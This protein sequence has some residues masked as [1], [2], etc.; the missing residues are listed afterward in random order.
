MSFL[1]GLF[2][3]NA[4]NRDL[5][6]ANASSS[7]ALAQGRQAAL[8]ALNAGKAP[9]Q[10]YINTGYDQAGNEIRTGM[11]GATGAINTGYDTARGDLTG[12]YGRAETAIGDGMGRARDLINPMIALGGKYD[13]MYADANGV[14]GADARTAFYDTNV[15]NNTDFNYADDLAAKQLEAKLNASGVTGGRA[16]ALQ[17]RQG[18]QRVEDRTNQM[19]ERIRQAGDRGAGFAGQLAGME[20]NAGTQV[21]GIRTGLGDRLGSLETARGGALGDLSMRGGQLQ[22]GLATGRGEA[23]AGTE[24]GNANA[25]A[26]IEQGYGNATAAN[27]I[28][29]GNAKAATRG[30][31]M[32][33]ML[34]IAGLAVKGFTPGVTGATPFGSMAKGFGGSGVGPWQTTVNR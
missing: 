21:A 1:D 17:L 5:A 34:G 27:A 32:N 8:D 25:I 29:Y 30:Q 26:G 7:A 6:A 13:A 24:S 31:G 4:K 23:L 20:A 28:N 15:R 9:A 16:G 10:G 22:A 2:G 33:A 11:A 12:N 19:L 14:N 18:A 3:G